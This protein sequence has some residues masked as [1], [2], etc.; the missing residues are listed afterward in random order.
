MIDNAESEQAVHGIGHGV[1]GGQRGQVGGDG[2]VV[3][4]YEAGRGR[5]HGHGSQLLGKGRL[6]PHITGSHRPIARLGQPVFVGRPIALYEAHIL[7]A[8]I[9]VGHLDDVGTGK[10]LQAVAPAQVLVPRQTVA[11]GANHQL[12]ALGY[13]LHGLQTAAQLGL[14]GQG[15][16][17]VG[18]VAPAEPV[19]LLAANVLGLGLLAQQVGDDTHTHKAGPLHGAA[20]GYGRHESAAGHQRV[21]HACMGFVVEQLHGQGEHIGIGAGGGRALETYQFGTYHGDGY[22]YLVRLL[23]IVSPG[24]WTGLRGVTSRDAAKGGVEQG[25]QTVGLQVATQNEAH[26]AS[27]VVVVIET[28]HVAEA[29]IFEVLGRTKDWIGVGGAVK[30]VAHDAVEGA[31]EQVVGR[32]VLLLVHRFQFALEQS[33]H[34]VYQSLAVERCPLRQVLWRKRIII[35]GIVVGSGSVEASTTIARYKIV[36]VVGDGILGRVLTELVDVALYMATRGSVGG[37]CQQVVLSRYGVKPYLLGAIVGRA[38]LVGTFEHNMFEVV[39]YARVR[40]V[41]RAGSHHHRAKHLGLRV[42]LVDPNGHPVLQFHFLYLQRLGRLRL[43]GQCRKYR[44]GRQE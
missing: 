26:V 43:D 3:K 29:R 8:Q 2:I 25:G 34:R 32:A 37:G 1:E 44:K 19:Y 16:R 11:K 33:E 5:S 35:I 23:P 10:V 7:V 36:E 42:V 9:A 15:Q 20:H 24:K 40:A 30:G 21:E 27:H 14:L 39:S 13:V 28:V 22:L 4:V 38:N 31:G 6:S 17:L 41:G 18:E 12:G